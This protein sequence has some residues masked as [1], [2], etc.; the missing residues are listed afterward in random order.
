MAHHVRG[1]WHLTWRYDG[2]S[3]EGRMAGLEAGN[4]LMD[5]LLDDPAEAAKFLKKDFKSSDWTRE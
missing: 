4:A 3:R 5:D 1:G 2:M